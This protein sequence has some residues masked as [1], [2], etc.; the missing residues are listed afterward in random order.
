MFKT[1]SRGPLG[2]QS[3]SRYAHLSRGKAM[4]FMC[5]TPK[6]HTN[7]RKV[8]SMC[9]VPQVMENYVGTDPEQNPS[10]LKYQ[11]LPY[12]DEA[13]KVLRTRL[14]KQPVGNPACQM[15]SLA[16]FLTASSG[17]LDLRKQNAN[18]LQVTSPPTSQSPV[19]NRHVAAA[20]TT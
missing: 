1:N 15:T 5:K 16:R 4:L 17:R 6:S 19:R 14:L 9:Y 11:C 20:S 8:S 3:F 18:C 13:L 10:N 7:V 2:K 12:G